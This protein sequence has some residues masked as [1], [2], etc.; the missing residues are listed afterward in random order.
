MTATALI[1]TAILVGAL[2]AQAVWSA[3]RLSIVTAGAAAA[4]LLTSISGVASTREL[5]AAVPWDVLVMLVALGLLSE[6]V[7]ESRLFGVLAMASTRRSGAD[8]TRL[9]VLFCVGMY[10]VSGLVNNLTA[11]LFV[12]PILLQLFKLLGVSQRYLTWSL[13]MVVVA[14]NLGGAAT[15][16]GDFPAILLLGSGNMAFGDYLVAAAP[17]TLA[18]LIALLAAVV[19]V[20]R[21]ARDLADSPLSRRLALAVMGALFRRV[22]IDRRVLL[23]A[24]VAT[25]AMLVAWTTLPADLVGPELICWLG[26]G[27]ALTAVPRTG[28]R[29][30]R[31]RIDMEAA[32][33]LLS[34]FVMVG[35][36]SRAGTFAALA[37]WLTTLPVSSPVQ[38]ALFLLFAG[39]ATGLFSAGPS[40]AA[41][42]EVAEA[43][44]ARM[45]PTAVYVGLALSVCAGSS[46]FL[47]AATSGPM[48]QIMTERAGLRDPRGA[49]LRFGFFAFV[50]VGLL[51]FAVIQSI[52]LAYALAIVA[53]A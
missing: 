20:V 7:I 22:T 29:L 25:A 18:A 2:A 9:L 49:P 50:P 32:L 44:A 40:M 16:I 31:T 52:A 36:V 1:A 10:V 12:L 41:L 33:F 43:L 5:L 19:L 27:G 42:L 30:L 51:A 15:P 26:V 6:L 35:A 45:P 53:M 14:C 3:W 46:L 38:L 28:E 23:P 39:L 8:P 17:P 13:G 21:P 11:I 24:A 37:D 48:A 4:C 34:L 47:T